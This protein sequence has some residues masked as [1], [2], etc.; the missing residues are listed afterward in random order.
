M[1]QRLKQRWLP[2]IAVLA[3]LAVLAGCGGGRSPGSATGVFKGAGDGDWTVLVYMNADNDLEPYG[4]INFNQMEQVGSTARVRIIV[5]FDRS[6]GYD[7]SNGN[8][9]GCRR[10]LVTKDSNPDII[11]STLLQDMGEVD[12]GS[13][14]TL[15]DFVRWGQQNYPASHY[16]LVIWNHGS[17][18]R[19]ATRLTTTPRNVSFDDTSGTSIRTVDMPYALAAATRPIDLL[20]FDASLMQMLEIAY[21]IRGSAVVLTGSEE[22]PPGE[23]YPYD[24]WLARLLAS[25]GMDARELGTAIS[26]EYV[27]YFAE[28]GHQYSVTQS[29]VDL[30]NIQPVAQAADDLAK[31]VIPHASTDADA[32]RAARQNAQAYAFDIYKDLLDYARVVNQLVPDPNISAAYSRL[33]SALSAAVL[34]EAHTGASVER[35]HGLSVYVPAPGDYLTRYE[36]LSF[37]RDYPNWAAWLK[38]QKL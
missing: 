37:S 36:N 1:V 2:L 17:G 31:A 28:P 12:M 35:G 9:T 33:Q 8:W 29:V 6:P 13:P 21:E 34:F 38:A 15:R 30:A 20:A 14:D 32:L 16:C 7:S 3:A 11:N 18:W 4:I 24:R 25:P 22:S 5:Q 10:Y 26:Q 27:G 23:G 19:M